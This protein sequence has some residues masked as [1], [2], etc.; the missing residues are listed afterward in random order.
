VVRTLPLAVLMGAAVMGSGAC[1]GRVRGSRGTGLHEAREATAAAW[2]NALGGG[3]GGDEQLR[4]LTAEALVY[5][6]TGEND[7]G[8]CDRRVSR[9]TAAFAS[10]VSCVRA[11]PYLR[12]LSDGV[13]VYRDA[14]RAD[15][16][17]NAALARYLPHVVDGTDAWSR[18]VGAN[19]QGR[20]AGTF[21]ALKKEVGRDGD[22]TTIAASGLYMT[23]VFRVQVVG[24]ADAA[25]VGAA[26]VD[27]VRTSD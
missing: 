26:L 27:V 24:G 12:E 22:W 20:A 7:E 8:S 17:R 23:I 11:T 6:T 15:S 3:P 4:Q 5:R 9:D 21:D 16:G 13:K 14:L 1:Q 18:Y 25:R 2:V 19:E 10:W